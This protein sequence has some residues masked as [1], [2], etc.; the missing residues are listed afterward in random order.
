M[1]LLKLLSLPDDVQDWQGTAAQLAVRL[2]ELLPLAGLES[3]GGSA[4]ERLI[5][6]YVTQGILTEPESR[7][8][9]RMFGFT[10]IIEFLVAR[11]LLKDGWPLAKIREL[12]RS[13]AGID[14]L[15]QL[16][17]AARNP[18]PAEAALER[19]R[20]HSDSD[21][22]QAVSRQAMR[23]VISEPSEELSLS[24]AEPIQEFRTRNSSLERATDLTLRRSKLR[25]DL[26][27]LGNPSGRAHRRQVMRI[28][29]TPW[30]QVLIDARNLKTM[31]PTTPQILG[32]ALTRVLEEERL[33]TGEKE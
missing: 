24:F 33:I 22:P 3:D 11:Q 6:Y 12:I 16:S 29:L 30:C 17:P 18:T 26:Q 2:N 1:T 25:D 8:R 32:D 7:G 5:R 20:E 28:S 14:G 19:I 21:A 23:S 27:T 13:S 10:Q 15:L 4:N 31:D 9:E